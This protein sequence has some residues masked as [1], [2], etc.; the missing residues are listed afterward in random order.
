MN[1]YNGLE[2][3]EEYEIDNALLAGNHD[4][5]QYM[6]PEFA[7]VDEPSYS[8]LHS[9]RWKKDFSATVEESAS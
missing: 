2:L 6:Q 1:C 4:H 5:V 7:G 8:K 3:T 9:N